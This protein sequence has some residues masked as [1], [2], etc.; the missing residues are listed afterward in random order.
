MRFVPQ[1]ETAKAM[2]DIPAFLAVP[3]HGRSTRR[4]E[5]AG[6]AEI[7]GPDSLSDPRQKPAGPRHVSPV[8][9]AELLDQLFFFSG[10][11][12]GEQRN[13]HQAASAM[14][15]LAESRAAPTI[16]SAAVT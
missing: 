4:V 3:T 13:H 15:Q 5:C 8:L 2:P 12:R 11:A 6:R 14:N 1:A 16:K 7:Q 10:R 9:V